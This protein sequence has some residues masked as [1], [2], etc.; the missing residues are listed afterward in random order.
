MVQGISHKQFEINLKTAAD[1]LSAGKDVNVDALVRAARKNA[2]NQTKGLKLEKK[3]SGKDEKVDGVIIG[4]RQL[5]EFMTTYRKER[6]A[7]K[8]I[9][10]TPSGRSEVQRQQGL[11][12]REQVTHRMP[13]PDREI[14]IGEWMAADLHLKPEKAPVVQENANKVVKAMTAEEKVASEFYNKNPEAFHEYAELQTSRLNGVPFDMKKFERKRPGR[15][16]GK[17]KM[18]ADT[19]KGRKGKKRRQPLRGPSK[20][21]LRLNNKDFNPAEI[22]KAYA[23]LT[24][25]GFLSKSTA[26]NYLRVYSTS[27]G[28]KLAGQKNIT[29]GEVFTIGGAKKLVNM[30]YRGDT[31][32]SA[33][34]TRKPIK[35]V[36][37]MD[38]PTEWSIYV[39]EGSPVIFRGTEKGMFNI[40]PKSLDTGGITLPPGSELRIQNAR[41]TRGVLRI[42]AEVLSPIN[43][44]IPGISGEEM[45]ASLLKA[46]GKN[47][48]V[49]N[50]KSVDKDFNQRS[51]REGP[52]NTKAKM[53]SDVRAQLDQLS[54]LNKK[55]AD[56][57]AKEFTDA[58]PPIKKKDQQE[59]INC[60]T[61][62]LFGG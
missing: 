18:V 16:T 4:D 13:E 11:F 6:I 17:S 19:R 40:H 1:Q 62:F 23:L 41:Y 37:G 9:I 47:D 5:D 34:L 36:K 58:F 31:F 44:R 28:L 35:D 21:I 53:D 10:A 29:I 32:H 43:K 7:G 30:V 22:K 20:T 2:Y 55:S 59:F 27:S 61:K 3:L 24:S 38:R 57:I 33:S 49:I 26:S 8:D 50:A 56:V 45:K 39:P 42:E 12:E 46:H 15:L 51:L 60:L 52:D 25:P 14:T 54:S 48:E